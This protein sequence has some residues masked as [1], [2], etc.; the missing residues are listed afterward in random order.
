[1]IFDYFDAK[2]LHG[3]LFKND[4]K[5]LKDETR[6][7]KKHEINVEKYVVLNVLRREKKSAVSSS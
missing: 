2:H 1:M 3:F 4:M 5:I 7:K 6:E